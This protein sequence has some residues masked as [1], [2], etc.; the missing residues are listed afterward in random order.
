MSYLKRDDMLKRILV[1]AEKDRDAFVDALCG[2]VQMV[3][4]TRAEIARINGLKGLGLK[5]ALAR[6]E[7]GV[8]LAC[9]FSEQWYR[10]VADAYGV[11][12]E[13][14]QA[15]SM[16]KLVRA[17]RI[18]RFGS[19]ALEVEMRKMVLLP[20]QEIIKKQNHIA[21]TVDN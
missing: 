5:E 7:E 18:K 19:T 16:S 13:A 17:F 9:L 3:D 12:R 20:F 2:D 15:M 10:G 1:S 4:V 8:R 6:D 14:T 11:G 21:A